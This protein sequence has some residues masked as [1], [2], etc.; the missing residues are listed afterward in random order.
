MIQLSGI[1]KPTESKGD[2]PRTRFVYVAINPW[3]LYYK[4]CISCENVEQ[5]TWCVGT[6]T[7]LIDP[8]CHS[9]H[10]DWLPRKTDGLFY[11][12]KNIY[13]LLCGI[14]R[15][16]HEAARCTCPELSWVQGRPF[17]V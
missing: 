4:C 11:P 13:R 12:T 2:N 7:Y 6:A 17:L 8:Q 5:C 15:Y 10:K 1:Y 9:G 14:A 16:V 3:Q